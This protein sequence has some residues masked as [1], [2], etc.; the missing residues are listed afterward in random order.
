MNARKLREEEPEI[1]VIH[2]CSRCMRCLKNEVYFGCT[3]CKGLILCLECLSSGA[4]LGTHLKEHPYF[5]ISPYVE[6]IFRTDWS[7]E[8]EIRLLEAIERCGLGNW[9]EVS[10]FMKT[11]TPQECHTHYF[12]CYI[13]SETAPYPELEIREPDDV[14]PDPSF[15]TAPVESYPSCGHDVNLKAANKRERTTP[16]EISGYMPLRN[17]CED[18]LADSA[19]STL[20]DLKFDTATETLV[21]FET[22]L[23]VLRQYSKLVKIRRFR[24]KNFEEL[25]IHTNGFKGFGATTA[26]EKE[27]ERFI[28]PFTPYLGKAL[29]AEIFKAIRE[30]IDC[31]NT[32]ATRCRWVENGIRNHSEG[33]LFDS[34]TALIQGETLS[35]A[36]FNQWTHLIE[37]YQRDSINN[38]SAELKLLS[39]KE[40]DLCLG[41]DIN[42]HLFIA[43]KDLLLREYAIRGSISLD[44]AR[45]LTDDY[46][47]QI[48]LIYEL[49]RKCHW[50]K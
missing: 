19:E 38:D 45:G 50:I 35:P 33:M 7:G 11:K 21:S 32:I 2:N 17:E 40:R 15:P 13:R 8:D 18:E 22:K 41:E 27:I 43:L 9:I 42:P 31:R 48:A 28:L 46:K 25:E 20:N 4:T 24:T 23:A 12:E 29:A 30:N 6:P 34:L 39:K 5:T 14:Y 47:P 26:D 44:D 16:G 36:D 10:R 49:F 37:N 3:V 1:T